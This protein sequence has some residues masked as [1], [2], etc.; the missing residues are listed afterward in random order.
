MPF[1]EYADK[2]VTTTGAYKLPDMLPFINKSDMAKL[3]SLHYTRVVE[4]AIGFKKWD[5]INLDA[6]GGLIPHK[7]NKDL[8]GILFLSS[9]FKNR[10]AKDG[11]L[12]S[13]FMG[14]TRN[15]NIV[16]LND[17]TIFKIIEQQFPKLMKINKFN[18]DLF[19][20][21]RHH[22]AIPQYYADSGERF[23]TIE[24]LQEKYQKLFIGGNLRNG[25][26]M[27]DRIQQGKSLA[28]NIINLQLK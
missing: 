24:L 17:D 1:V 19:E 25:I 15:E 28:E 13:I 2:I 3:S 12:F 20:I 6:F 21:K 22:K 14:G 9:L 7:E 16:E 18:P 8:L 11:A 26:G 27:A 10:A 5:G 23:K 4:I